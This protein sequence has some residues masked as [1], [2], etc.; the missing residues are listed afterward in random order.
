[1]KKIS[2]IAILLISVVFLS[3]C[4]KNTEKSNKA[5]NQKTVQKQQNNENQTEIYLVKIKQPEVE[6][7]NQLKEPKLEDIQTSPNINSINPGGIDICSGEITAVKVDGKLSPKEALEKIFTYPNN[8]AQGIYNAFSKSKNIKI[9]KLDIKNNFAIVTLSGDF[10]SD[11][12]SCSGRLMHDQIVKTLSQF[13]NIAGA[14][15]FVGQEEITGYLEKL[16]RE[17]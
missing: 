11:N 17:K 2:I 6:N 3:A 9:D 13:D 10:Q 1:M 5:K 4:N 14:D 8:P 15:I 12:Y 16:S 7:D